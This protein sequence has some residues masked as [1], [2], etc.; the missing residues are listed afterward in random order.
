MDF[1]LD[2]ECS[3]DTESPCPIS[4]GASLALAEVIFTICY[5]IPSKISSNS[6]SQYFHFF[7]FLMIDFCGGN[8]PCYVLGYTHFVY[9]AF[10]NF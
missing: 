10:D 5:P 1:E 6:I 9:T 8:F 2:V 3:G 7:L 4:S